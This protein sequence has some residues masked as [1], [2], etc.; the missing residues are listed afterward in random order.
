[1]FTVNYKTKKRQSKYLLIPILMGIYILLLGVTV[2]AQTFPDAPAMDGQGTATSCGN[3]GFSSNASFS[4]QKDVYD[5]YARLGSTSETETDDLY[6]K[7][8]TSQDCLH[9]GRQVL[10]SDSWTKVGSYDANVSG[11][12]KGNFQLAALS[13]G[14][15]QSFN[16]PSIL[17]VS[18]TKP[19]CLPTTECY[20][21]IN[22]AQGAVRADTISGSSDTLFVVRAVNPNDDTLNQVQYYVDNNLAYAKTDYRPFDMRYV[23]PGKHSLN[24]I[25]HYESG[26]R[27]VVTKNVDKDWLSFDSKNFFIYMFYGQKG[28][29]QRLFIVSLVLVVIMS[30]VKIIRLVHKRAL[31]KR[32]HLISYTNKPLLSQRIQSFIVRHTHP[33][34][35]KGGSKLTS[36]IKVLS[37]LVPITFVSLAIIVLVN[38]YGMSLKQVD[39]PSMDSTFA[40]GEMVVVNRLGQT[41]GGLTNKGYTPKRGEVVILNRIL[42]A[43]EP[44]ASGSSEFLIKRVIGLPGERVVVKGAHVTIYNKLH[45]TGYEPDSGSTWQKTMHLDDGIMSPSTIDITLQADEVFV[46]GDNRPNSVDSR[47]FGPIQ[48]KYILGNVVKTL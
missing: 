18:Q 19:A 3:V 7:P 12:D 45:L 32:N 46:C 24:A 36:G 15:I 4:V 25:L 39:G 35:N 41:W 37:Y 21:S 22:G 43:M 6:V 38:N 30:F 31:W 40:S 27:V 2:Y 23:S 20:V 42:N 5:V 33:L 13:S 47:S 17:L 1:M 48:A 28:I 9:I 11:H 14:I 34:I 10:R 16:Q 44:Q 8:G 26:Q 29:L